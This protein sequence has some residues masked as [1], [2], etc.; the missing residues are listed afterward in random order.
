MATTFKMVALNVMF[1]HWSSLLI[2]CYKN[3]ASNFFK[4]DCKSGIKLHLVTDKTDNLKEWVP[5]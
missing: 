4:I 1:R 2:D 3:S 5:F